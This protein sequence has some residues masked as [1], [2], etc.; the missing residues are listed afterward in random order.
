MAKE[1]LPAARRYAEI[2]PASAHALHMPSHIFARLGLWRDVIQSNLASKASAEKQHDL[3]ARVHAMDFLVYAYVQS[4]NLAQAKAMEIE[5]LS[6]KQQHFS[7]DM[8][9]FISSMCI[10]PPS[11]R[12]R[13]RHGKRPNH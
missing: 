11:S 12:L 5:A 9:A 1:A 10:F 6:I 13:L 2:A 7:G 3:A 8:T 4:G